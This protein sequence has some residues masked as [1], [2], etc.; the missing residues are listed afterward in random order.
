[1]FLPKDSLSS[2]EAPLC[3]REAGRNE[4]K[5]RE[6]RGPACVADVTLPL[7]STV[8]EAAPIGTLRSNDWRRQE[9]RLKSEFA[10]FQSL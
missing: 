7:F 2:A 1:M 6:A 5:A 4:K 10:F 8:C 9:R 3:R